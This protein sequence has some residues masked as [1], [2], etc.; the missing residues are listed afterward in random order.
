MRKWQ[1][2][3]SFREPPVYMLIAVCAAS[4]DVGKLSVFVSAPL[5][6]ESNAGEDILRGGCIIS[7]EGAWEGT[8]ERE[9]INMM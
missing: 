3:V 2:S 5:W 7:A 4:V 6:Q 8:Y 1:T 9:K